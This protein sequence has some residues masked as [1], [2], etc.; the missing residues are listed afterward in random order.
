MS[1]YY[2]DCFLKTKKEIVDTLFN[3]FMDIIVHNELYNRVTLD[4]GIKPITK[5][6]RYGISDDIMLPYEDGIEDIEEWFDEEMLCYFEE[7]DIDIDFQLVMISMLHLG[8]T[9]ADV[10]DIVKRQIIM[11]LDLEGILDTIEHGFE[12]DE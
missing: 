4:C 9:K 2:E 5:R 6:E 12:F 3:Y 7:E 1:Y 8:I 11:D 10:L